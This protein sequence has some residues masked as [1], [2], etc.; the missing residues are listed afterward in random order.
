MG[1]VV[2]AMPVLRLIKLHQPSSRVFWWIEAGLSGLLEGDPDLAGFVPFHRHGWSS[3]G[4]WRQLWKDI[5]WM[6]AQEFDWVIDLQCLARSGVYAWL[7]NGK[8]TYGLDEPREGA[9]CLYDNVTRRSRITPHAVDWYLDMLPALGIPKRPFT[10]LPPRPGAAASIRRKWPVDPRPWIVL[11]PGARWPNKCWP[12]DYYKSAARILSRAHPNLGFAI[13]GTANEREAA[14]RIREAAPERTLDLTGQ[15]SLPE[16]IEWIRSSQ[17]VIGNDS[18][19]MH[20]AAALDKPVVAIFGPTDPRRTGPY[21]QIENVLRVQLP[22]SPCMRD[23]CRSPKHLE[24]LHAVTP[25]A[26]A[27]AVE[28][29]LVRQHAG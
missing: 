16:M 27:R 1:D 20:V 11:Q 7:A 12:A 19:P 21:N 10:W 26:V 24:C 23:K 15:V 5:R 13:L 2:Q 28:K 17:L 14:A 4:R 9:R 8:M 18:G 22:C 3:F 29:I 6:R 25:E